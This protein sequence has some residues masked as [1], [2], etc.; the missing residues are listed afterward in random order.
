M[1]RKDRKMANWTPREVIVNEAI[2]NDSATL[3]ILERCAGVP[4]KY[5]KSGQ[6]TEIIGA[7]E[8]LRN[9]NVSMLDKILAGKSVMY[10]APAGSAVDTFDMPDTRMMCPH[11]DR[12]KLASNGC[13]Y[14]C[15]WCYLKLTYRAAFPFITVRVQYDKIKEQLQRR[16]N[17][18][19]A[20]ILFNTGELADS[21][22]LDHLTGAGREFIPWFGTSKNGY[23]LALTKSDNV[24]DILDLPHNK[25]TI[26]TWSMNEASISKKFEIGAPSFE[27][28]LAAAEKVHAAGYPVRV[29]LD[30]IVPFEG[31]R[32]R[33]AATVREIFERL[34]PERITMGTLRFEEAF[35]KMRDSLLTS[36]EEL[37]KM[38][39]G[40]V[41]M[42]PKKQF[43]GAKRPK[44]GKYSFSENQ[45]TEIFAFIIDEIRKYSDIPIALCKESFEVWNHLGLDVTKCQ[46]V[47]QFEGADLSGRLAEK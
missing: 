41:P 32:D 23:L 33:Y 1:N 34:T 26:V 45:R 19:T 35:F 15:D 37:S 2:K 36:G 20:P 25:H 27:R 30:P 17:V 47:C 21:L 42:F 24:N 8:T 10:I 14:Q 22:A 7:S 6:N 29:R 44:T 5:V 16:I 28:R 39:S 40:M 38:L 4:I 9:A 13:F 12:L 18:T 43:A 3:R 11:F 46:C 31:W